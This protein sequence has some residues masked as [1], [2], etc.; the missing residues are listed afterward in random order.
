MVWN[1]KELERTCLGIL[2]EGGEMTT[3]DLDTEI[4][5]KVKG[6]SLADPKREPLEKALW[7]LAAQQKIRHR[8][9]LPRNSFEL[10]KNYWMLIQ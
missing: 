1:E 8:A 3:G 10:T 7:S 9:Q 5:R 2:R 4:R 6:T